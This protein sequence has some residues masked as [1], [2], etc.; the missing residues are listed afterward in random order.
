MLDRR[1]SARCEAVLKPNCERYQLS[2]RQVIRIMPG[3][4][5]QMIHRDR[6]SWG[7]FLQGVEPQLNTIWALTDLTR[8][9]CTTQV[10]PR[11]SPPPPKFHNS[12]LRFDS[13][14][15]RARA[16]RPTRRRRDAAIGQ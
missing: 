14:R 11:S 9:S 8:E 12:R 15:S 4:K 16:G 10:A 5:A 6:W 1:V 2:L 3:E 7:R 13:K